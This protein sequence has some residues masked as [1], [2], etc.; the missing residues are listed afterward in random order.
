[1]NMDHTT[2]DFGFKKVPLQEKA[3]LVNQVFTSVANKY[4]LMNDLMSFGIH[5][6][7]KKIAIQHCAIRHNQS[8][9]DLAGGTGDLANAFLNELEGT[10]QVVLADINA[11][12]LQAGKVK[13]IN[14]GHLQNIKYTQLNAECLPFADNSFDCIAIGFGL[15]N[16]TQ[17]QIALQEMHRVLKP[18]GR[19]VILEFSKPIYQHLSTA[20]D[21]YSF[22]VLPFLGK[23]VAQDAE[24][25]R[26]LA[27]SIRMHPGQEDLKSMM[28][29]AGF[30]NCSY[31]NLTGGICAIHKGFKF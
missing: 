14:K 1:M 23:M 6:L 22:K 5:R 9:L 10:G 4:D 28:D 3:K 18:G 29:L 8:I 31:Q 21:I 12:M 26:Y 30:E 16:V 2:T 13:L 27:E 25:Y 11:E 17:K 20:Y 24:S 19:V 7:W 15:R